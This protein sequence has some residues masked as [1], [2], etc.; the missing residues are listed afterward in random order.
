MNTFQM[1]IPAR[2]FME[3]G[4]NIIKSTILLSN[5]LKSLPYTV[6]AK[7]NNMLEIVNNGIEDKTHIDMCWIIAN[8][9][10]H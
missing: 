2:I 5:D 3:N 8:V 7:N 1:P 9:N 10:I 6:K 4:G